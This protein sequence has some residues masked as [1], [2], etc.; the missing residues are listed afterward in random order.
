MTGAFHLVV[1][2]FSLGQRGFGVA[3]AITDG[4]HRAIDHKDSDAML[5]E[6]E[7][8]PHPLF[9]IGEL[10]D[11]DPVDHPAPNSALMKR[12]SRTSARAG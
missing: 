12:R 9:E 5:V 11:L 3:A 8:E 6:L 2:D 4:K 1:E 7:L 10:T